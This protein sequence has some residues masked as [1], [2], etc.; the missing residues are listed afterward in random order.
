[1]LAAV[2]LFALALA[3]V[4]LSIR[5]RSAQVR[6]EA[7]RE[8]LWRFQAQEISVLVRHANEA[9]SRAIFEFLAAEERARADSET[10]KSGAARGAPE[11][12]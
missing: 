2:A 3:V 7:L 11:T 5:L 1:M 10:S 12:R 4:V 8:E 6:E 9:R